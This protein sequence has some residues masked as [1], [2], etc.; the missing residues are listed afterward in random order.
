M[1]L[2]KDPPS[3]GI[4]NN[5][6]GPEIVDIGVTCSKSIAVITVAGELDLSNTMWL[7]ECLHDAI[8]A[9]VTELVLNIADLTYMDSTGLSILMGAHTRMQSAGGTFT[10]TAPMPIVKKLFAVTG[11]VPF[12]TAP[13][14][15]LV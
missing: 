3:Y 6:D 9:G 1:F 8:D 15:V 7:F 13:A 12:L 14:A 4:I 11:G 2:V 10:V 5:F